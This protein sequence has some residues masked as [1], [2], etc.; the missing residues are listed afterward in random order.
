MKSLLI[1]ALLLAFAPATEAAVFA[2]AECHVRFEVPAR[3]K[4]AVEKAVRGSVCII[5]VEPQK[6]R[7]LVKENEGLNLWGLSVE[8]HGRSLD[9]ALPESSFEKEDGQWQ[10]LGRQ[11]LR[12]DA[13]EIEGNGWKGLRGTSQSGCHFEEGGYAGLCEVEVALISNGKWSAE[14]IASPRSHKDFETVLKKFRF[15]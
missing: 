10:I 6:V 12:S 9:Q 13:R 7:Q 3:R 5:Y 8:V 11:G 4:V 1:G 2:R 14:I 15:E